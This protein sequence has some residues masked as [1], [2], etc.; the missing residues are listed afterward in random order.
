MAPNTE[1]T[2]AR[3]LDAAGR[4]FARDGF[5]R[6]NIRDICAEAEAN[7]AAVNYHFGGKEKLYLA[8]WEIAASKMQSAET[9]PTLDGGDNPDAVLRRFISWFMRL[10]ITNTGPDNW[11]GDLLAHETADPTPAAMS[12][13][14]ERCCRPVRDELRRIV[15][16]RIDADPTSRRVNDIVYGL[17][18]MCINPKHSASIY[19]A[20]GHEI[21][22]DEA[23]IAVLADTIADLALF[24]LTGIARDRDAD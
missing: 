19:A 18:A 11:T 10:V 2:R 5:S 24:G 12:I 9:M 4:L 13:F 14:V 23:D 7:Q 1:P 16:A 15:S 3:L 8:V 17:I 6:T 22:S 21:P 20:L